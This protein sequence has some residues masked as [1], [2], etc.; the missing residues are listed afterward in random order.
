CSSR[1]P[2]HACCSV[3]GATAPLSTAS[4]LCAPSLSTPGIL[5]AR[6]LLV[7]GPRR[8]A[9]MQLPAPPALPRPDPATGVSGVT[10]TLVAIHIAAARCGDG[11][12][13]DR[14]S[15]QARRAD[16]HGAAGRAMTK[17]AQLNLLVQKPGVG[18]EKADFMWWRQWMDGSDQNL[19]W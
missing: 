11:S 9:V 7:C 8:V 1:T 13:Q 12:T 15:R 16:Q 10:D 5:S 6:V 14:G 17:L 19:G 18:K 3:Q 2:R 4:T